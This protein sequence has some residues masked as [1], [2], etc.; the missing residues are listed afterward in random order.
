MSLNNDK[1]P[2]YLKDS[3]GYSGW[4]K[5][6]FDPDGSDSSSDIQFII[7]IIIIIIIIISCG[8]F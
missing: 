7:V 6:G 2:S 8:P 3:S 1:N 5:H 4:F